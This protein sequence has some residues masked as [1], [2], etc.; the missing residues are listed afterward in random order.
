[1][2][3]WRFGAGGNGG[4]HGLDSRV[5]HVESLSMGTQRVWEGLGGGAGRVYAERGEERGRTAQL[6]QRVGIPP[7]LFPPFGRH[8]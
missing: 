4:G 7:K 5:R 6:L 3:V 2:T 8:L 1:M